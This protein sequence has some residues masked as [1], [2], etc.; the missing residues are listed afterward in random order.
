MFEK[1]YQYGTLRWYVARHA[2][3]AA[4][5]P[6]ALWTKLPENETPTIFRWG[7]VLAPSSAQIYGATP[8]TTTTMTFPS[9]RSLYVDGGLCV[10]GRAVASRHLIGL[11]DKWCDW[12]TAGRS[13]LDYCYF[14]L[15]RTGRTRPPPLPPPQAPARAPPPPPRHRHRRRRRRLLQ[16]RLLLPP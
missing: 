9:S 11:N 10:Y 15:N 13:Q 5:T 16:M 7:T 8:T 6:C 2:R 1:R 3:S 12:T 4:R 14:E